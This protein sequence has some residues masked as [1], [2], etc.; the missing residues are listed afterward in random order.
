MATSR[1]WRAHRKS[2]VEQPEQCQAVREASFS[3]QTA[4]RLLQVLLSKLPVSCLEHVRVSG[5]EF[6]L[7]FLFFLSCV[8][9]ANPHC[10]AES[11]TLIRSFFLYDEFDAQVMQTCAA[12]L[13]AYA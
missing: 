8:R 6:W 1:C 12:L 5:G 7:L 2:C 3:T 11:M 9:A 13:L 10:V 4:D